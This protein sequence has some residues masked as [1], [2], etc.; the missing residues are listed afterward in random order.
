V[1]R[2][3]TQTKIKMS[4]ELLKTIE[5][6]RAEIEELKWEHGSTLVDLREENEQLRKKFDQ[7][8]EL[9]MGL[10]DYNYDTERTHYDETIDEDGEGGEGHIFHTLVKIQNLID[11][12]LS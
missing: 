12:E 6:L 1:Y 11:S 2:V 4:K 3:V 5:E 9:S 10:V 8:S 7:L